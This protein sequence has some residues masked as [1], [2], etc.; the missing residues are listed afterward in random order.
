MIVTLAISQNL[1]SKTIALTHITIYKEGS[2]FVFISQTIG[3][4]GGARKWFHNVETHGPRVIENW[5]IL[6]KKFQQFFF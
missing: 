6:S 2:L 4:K 3:Y 5:T 1:K